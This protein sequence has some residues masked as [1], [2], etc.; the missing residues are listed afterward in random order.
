[1]PTFIDESGDT[2]RVAGA[3]SDCFRLAA[4]WVPSHD[5]ADAMREGVARLRSDLGIRTDYEFKYSKTHAHPERRTNFFR[6]ALR[7]EFRFAVV[8]I[9]KLRDL[10]ARDSSSFIHWATATHLAATLRPVYVGCESPRL[11]ERVIVD[12]NRDGRFLSAVETAF[13]G[14][15]AACVPKRK[16]VKDAK[17]GDS[18]KDSLLQLADM[19]CGAAGSYFDGD[20]EW[21]DLIAERDLD[22]QR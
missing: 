4:V 1:M 6:T 17:F 20:R 9:D 19:V 15:G 14:L 5:I 3:S 12:D 8:S 18:K 16:L 2:G 11:N 7:F 13:R 22:R 10:S 21:Y